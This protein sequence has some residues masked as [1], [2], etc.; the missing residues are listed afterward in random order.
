MRLH[1]DFPSERRLRNNGVAQEQ[2]Q[3]IRKGARNRFGRETGCL[4]EG[5]G[6]ASAV[7]MPN[8]SD[9]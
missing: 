3:T 5:A 8:E 9:E 2:E 4:C 1:F 7:A 6:G